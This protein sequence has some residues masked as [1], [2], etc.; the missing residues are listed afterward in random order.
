MGINANG[1]FF[2][3]APDEAI[4]ETERRVVHFVS[5]QRGRVESRRQ[6]ILLRMTPVEELPE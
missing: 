2:P 5:R 4:A 3:C 1:E 6:V